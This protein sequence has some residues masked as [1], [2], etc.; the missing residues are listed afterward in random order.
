MLSLALSLAFLAVP[1]V[2]AT[3]ATAAGVTL[4][5][6][7]KHGSDKNDGRSWGEAFKTIN[8][9]ARKIP[10]GTAAAGWTV[11]VRGYDDY[12]YRERPVPGAYDRAGTAGA[13]VV[14]T[15]EGWSPGADDYVKPIVSGALVAPRPGKSWQADSTNGVWSTAWTDKPGGFN[16]GKPYSAAVFQNRTGL[17]WQHGS[18]ADLRGKARRG[19]GG[20]WWDNGANRLYVATRN[21]VAPGSVTIDVPVYMGFYFTGSAGARHISV[22]GF[23]V[24]HTSMGIQFHQGADYNSAYDNEAVGN[25]PM[26]F[27]TSGRATRSGFDPGTGNVFLRNTASWSTLQG[28]KVDAGSQDTVICDNVVTHNA[29]QGIKVQ[30]PNNGS[31][32]RATSGTEVCRNVLALQNKRRPGAG[33]VDERPNGLTLTNGA[34]RSNVHDN[35]IRNNTVGVQVNQGGIGSPISYTTFKRN[36]VF[37]NAGP[38]LSLRDGVAAA[39]SGTGPW[40]A[41]FNVY[42]DNEYGIRMHEGSTNK[43]FRHETVYDN[44]VAGILVG[45]TCGPRSEMDVQ[46]SL[47]THNGGYGISIAAGQTVRLRYVGVGSNKSGGVHGSASKYKLNTKSAGYLSRDPASSQF[48][49][50]ATVSYQY[51][52]GPNA[53]PIGAR[54]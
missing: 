13:P 52:A 35:V 39:R 46:E 14:F 36:Q 45:C 2:P 9:A 34:R 12:L 17:L 18:L 54:Y 49:Q 41:S 32:P 11:V 7:G 19:D 5:V 8:H 29:L 30:G 53:S 1:V 44:R 6:D 51:T 15:A 37:G 43:V 28:F 3:P 23:V 20:Y 31:D 26:A 16:A 42:W 24:Q 40:T 50:I 4:F 33:R 22:R 21:G 48:L 47:V 27:G 25:I 10:H 38:G